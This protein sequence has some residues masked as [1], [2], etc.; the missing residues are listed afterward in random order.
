MA[1]PLEL[2]AVEVSANLTNLD[3]QMQGASRVVDVNAQKIVQSVENSERAI[4]QSS[5]RSSQAMESTGGSARLLGQ[6]FSQMG[7]Q[8][9]AGTSPLQAFA[10]QLPDLAVVMGQTQQQAGSLAAFFAGP[11]G[12]ALTTAASVAL[13]M[14]AGIAD[15]DDKTKK[16]EASQ[17]SLVDVLADSTASYEEV[18]AAAAAYAKQNEVVRATTINVLGAEAAAISSRLKLALATRQLLSAELERRKG[19]VSGSSILAPTGYQQGLIARET[20]IANRAAAN[21]KQIAALEGAAQNVTTRIV[22]RL[23]TL[24]SDPSAKIS[25]GFEILRQ[26]ARS[27]I[28][29]VDQ[30]AD[31][32]AALNRQE[33]RALDKQRQ[34]ERSPTPRR[35]TRSAGKTEAEREAAAAEKAAEKLKEQYE[36]TQ[37]QMT[38]EQRLA[39][40]RGSGSEAEAMLADMME[41]RARIEQQ[42]PELARSTREEDQKRLQVL[43]DIANATIGEGYQRKAAKEA[44]EEQRKAQET[45]KRQRERDAVEL[46]HQ[47]EQQIRT[48][49][50]LYEDAFRGGTKAIWQ[51]FKD[52]GFRV[53]AQVLARFT[54]A[55]LGGGGGGSFNLGGAFASAIG[56]VLPGFATGGS[57]AIGGRGGTDNNVLAVNGRPVARVSNGETL[58]ITNPNLAR[59]AGVGLRAQVIQVDA[60]GAVMNDQFASQILAQARAWDAQ[61]GSSVAKGVLAA[62]PSRVAS[63]QRD[64]T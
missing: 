26:R 61:M 25:E 39:Q 24:R 21:E 14:A 45:L 42:F 7:Q 15:A 43:L 20:A 8:I 29:D 48:L 64:G 36:R 41:A 1:D 13:S 28:K 59:G 11:W 19:E 18:A 44:A 50:S 47:Q 62:V 55:K 3:K 30:L 32:L 12:L 9:A 31:R 37:A 10:I 17:R 2:I 23:A 56:S 52:I 40:L 6:Q 34:S 5:I 38:L 33:E 57:I 16:A 4:V 58:H 60:R 53:V 35:S 46:A 49:G 54:I 27:T 63:Y 22:D 51:D